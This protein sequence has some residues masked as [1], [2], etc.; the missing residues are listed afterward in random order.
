MRT[1]GVGFKVAC[2]LLALTS[3]S[4]LFLSNYSVFAEESSVSTA[5]VTINQSCSMSGTTNT[6]HTA[7]LANGTYSGSS[8]PNGIGQT[9]LKVFCNDNAGFA[10]YAIG[11]TGNEYGNTKLHNDTLGSNYDISTGK[12][13]SGTTVNST[14]S[15]KLTSVYGTYAPTIADGTNN[16]ENFTTWHEIPTEYTK[17]AYR[18]S[19]TDAD[20]NGQGT[21]SSLTTTYDAY[22]SATQPAGTYV[23]QVKYTLV[24]PNMT[25]NSNKPV[26]PLK[27]TDCPARNVCYAP[28]TNDIEGSMS[29]LGSI[30][31]SPKAGKNNVSGVATF[32]LIAPNYSRPGYGFAGWSTKWDVTTATNPIIYGPNETITVADLPTNEGIT[33][34]SKGLILYP[35]WIASAG[36]LQGW[37][38]CSSLTTAPTSTRA[39]LASM[40]ALTDTRDNNVY[41]VAR[42][43][44]GKCWMVENLRLDN[45]ATITTANTHNPLNINN[46]VTLKIDYANDTIANHLASSSNTW[47][48]TIDAACYDQTML[49]TNNINRGLTASYNGTGSTTYY[50]WYS[51]GNY[52]NWYSATAGN[53]TYS[54][55]NNNNS[56]TGDLCPAGWRLPIG[57]QTTVNTTG[58]FYVLTKTLMGGTEPNQNNTNGYGVYNGIVDNVNLGAK[59]SKSLRAFPNNFVYSGNLSGSSINSR[60]S[61][62]SGEYW[63]S[64]VYGSIYAFHLSFI[65]NATHPGT[66]NDQKNIGYSVRCVAQ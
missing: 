36:N 59:A 18:T 65:A 52:Y 66:D 14:W 31:G 42:L 22:V 53:G 58:D 9:T 6:A 19:T 11:Y 50:Q 4:I 12:Y 29:S 3:F 34:S 27:A 51:Y 7:N 1:I 63:S 54:F 21:G 60:G 44:D 37:S 25:D 38:G 20:N 15:M 62:S 10:I 16:T 24:H 49:N 45:T 41:A 55:N 43:A 5:T 47:C 2:S 13:T 35:V 8:Y 26:L 28:N 57:G 40:T 30:S 32:N 46:N 61:S 64:T 39:T 17:V 48:G 33:F 23:G 56:V